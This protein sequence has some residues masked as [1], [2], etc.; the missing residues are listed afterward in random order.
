[1]QQTS[2][3]LR[4]LADILFQHEDKVFRAQ[5]D[6]VRSSG[7]L[8]LRPVSPAQEKQSHNIHNATPQLNTG[9]LYN[10]SSHLLS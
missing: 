9:L 7:H 3:D 1:M 6:F 2:P 4:S 10:I 5:N 8:L